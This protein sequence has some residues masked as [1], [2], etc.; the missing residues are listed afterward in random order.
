M[1]TV[2]SLRVILN[3]TLFAGMSVEQPSEKAI[4]LTGTDENGEVKIFL[5][6]AASK[7]VSPLFDALTS[8]VNDLRQSQS[9][10]GSN[11]KS[12]E[13]PIKKSISDSPSAV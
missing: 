3:T 8:R 5:I 13:P 4:R 12:D 10:G 9:N 1:R 11:N 7:D 6:G 2:G